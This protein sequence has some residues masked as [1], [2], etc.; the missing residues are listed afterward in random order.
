MQVYYYINEY[1]Y[2]NDDFLLYHAEEDT[3]TNLNIVNL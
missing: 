1:F 3:V 2:K